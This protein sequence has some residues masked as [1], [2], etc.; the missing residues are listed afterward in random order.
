MATILLGAELLTHTRLVAR[1][2][3]D[4]VLNAGDRDVVVDASQVQA[5]DACGLGT[6]C[7][8][9][10]KA[11]ELGA[12]LTIRHPAGALDALLRATHLDLVLRVEYAQ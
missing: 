8:M 10:H 12:R 1:E 7:R 4:A 5:V 11:N 2:Q 6:L 3:I 9:N